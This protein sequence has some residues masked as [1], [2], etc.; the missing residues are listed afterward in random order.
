MAWQQSDLDALSAA[1]VAG[2]KSVTYSDGRKVEYH[3]GGSGQAV[4]GRLVLGANLALERNFSYGPQIGP[5]DFGSVDF[6]RRAVMLRRRGA[7]LRAIN[8]SLNSI[9][10]NEIEAKVLPLLE[11]IGNTETLAI[12]T[13][14]DAHAMRQRR[15]FFGPLIGDLLTVWRTAD[16]WTAGLN[17]LSL[18]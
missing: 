14:A 1:I 9:R 2:V 5:K 18:I 7:K 10:K 13:D 16:G 8:L 4:V 12:V 6:S 17:L 3:M 15:I 11:V